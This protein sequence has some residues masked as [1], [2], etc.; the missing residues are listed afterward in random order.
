M[1]KQRK[2]EIRAAIEARM[3]IKRQSQ[4]SLAREIG[5]SAAQLINIRDRKYEQVSDKML[6]RIAS[7]LGMDDWKIRRTRNLKIVTNLCA[8][9][10]ENHRFLAISAFTGA[11]KTTG[12]RHYAAKHP[13]AFYMHYN[14]LMS[15]RGNF[16]RQIQKAMGID[17]GG[18]PNELGM[19]I[20]GRLNELDHPLLIIDNASLMNDGNLALMQTIYDETEHHAGIVLAG[21]EFL[22]EYI[23]KGARKNKR[24]FRELKRRIAY[25]QPLY[26]PTPEEITVI[27]A[28]HGITDMHVINYIANAAPNYGSIRNL[29][30]NAVRMSA[31][32]SV[33]IDTEMLEQLALGDRAWYAQSVM[34]I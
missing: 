24:G 3:K 2:D 14:Q 22:K 11:G 29:I 6:N 18:S 10:Q 5:I 27:C 31:E 28:D 7:H 8:D 26:R 4:N 23:D 30:T 25:W 19:A 20:Y 34:S 17:E 21:T 33:A 13:N 1:N 16:F 12:L 15:G 9:A 32:H